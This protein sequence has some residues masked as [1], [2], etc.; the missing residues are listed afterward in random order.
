MHLSTLFIVLLFS[1]ILSNVLNRIFPR[2]PLPLIQILFGLAIS[3][4]F[5]GIAFELNTEI[6]LAF[7]IAPLLFREGEESDITSIL[8]NW[9]LILFLI[10][11][12]IFVS[13]IVMGF[14]AHSVLPVVVPLSA[15]LAIGAALG[16]TDLVAYSAIS[17][18]FSFPKWISYILQGEG[19][20]NDASGLVAFQV[21]V[22]ALTT[23]AFSLAAASLDLLVSVV[24]GFFIGLIAALFN[25]LFLSILDNVDAADV[26]GALLLEL[27]LPFVSYFIAE[28][29]HASGIIAVVVAGVSQASRF[30]KITVFDARL[31]SVSYTIWRTIAFVLNGMVFLLLGTEIPTLAKPVLQS[32]AYSNLWMLLVVVLLTAAMFSI[33]FV[34]IGTVFALRA[35][36]TDRPFARVLKSSLLLTFSGVKGTVSIA[37]ILLLPIA[38]MTE[39]EHSLLLFT[40]AGVTLLSFL[41]GIL[42]L[43]KLAG[44][45][46]ASTNPYM[47]IAILNDVVSELGKDLIQTEQPGA[48]YATIDNYNQRLE[49]LILEQESNAIKEELANIRLMMME[50]E[51]EGLE[52]AYR[53]NQIS[54]KEYRI[55]Q[56]YLKGL[57]RR[58]NRSLV[59]SLSYAFVVSIRGLRR[60]FHFILTF[61]DSFRK[62]KD[63]REKLRL[64][65]ANRDHIVEVYLT[66]T[67]QILEALS[68]LEGVYHSELLAYLKRN[69]LQ[70][71]EII[72]SG[73]FVERVITHLTPDNVD[74]MLRGYYLERKIIAEYEQNELISSRYAKR[75][76]NEVNILEDYSLKETSNTLTYDMINLARGR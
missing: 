34:M 40:V 25:R 65:E 24:G 20:L 15:C 51:S 76:R 45:P 10:F 41:I 30:K 73:A 46:A 4:W 8:R 14:L 75:L 49:N 69:R 74:E 29:I 33:R 60:A 17:K 64:T 22:T 59:S 54:N 27:V 52:Y 57:E 39:L 55:Y 44:S 1:L 36:R 13:T 11:P 32:T 38:N 6:F 42:V 72:Q 68:N 26:T 35:W 21:T 3:I 67:E 62:V 28:E 16:P 63:Y 2:L 53:Q 61:R 37:T 12:V 7:V 23:G 66:N 58:I 48:I 71:A 47:Q 18:R 5:K 50:I 9:K 70:E 56:R 31:D 43:P 19:L